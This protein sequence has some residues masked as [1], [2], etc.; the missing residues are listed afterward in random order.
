[1]QCLSGF[2]LYSRW[3][4]L[5]THFLGPLFLCL[6]ELYIKS[7]IRRVVGGDS[8]LARVCHQPFYRPFSKLSN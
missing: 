4:P 3:V 6:S 7:A 2:E 8:T 1:M 5:V